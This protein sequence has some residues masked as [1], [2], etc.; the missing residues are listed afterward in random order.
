MHANGYHKSRSSVATASVRTSSEKR[1]GVRG[2]VAVLGLIGTTLTSPS[3][4]Q[5]APVLGTV[6]SFAVLGASTVTNTGS[7]VLTGT[8][9]NPG[10]LGVSPGSAITGF[11]PGSLTG[12]AATIHLN[13]AVAIQAQIDLTKAFNTLTSKPATANLTG[14][15]LGGLTLTPGVY[16]FS[17]AAQLT[18]ALTLNGLGNP[19]SV[20]IFNIGSTLTTASASAISLINGAQGGNVFWRVGSSATL[21]TTTSFAGDILAN[22]SITL[23]TGA[24]ITCGAAWAETGAVTLDTNMIS[25]CDLIGGGGGAILGP[26]GVPLIAS[27][28]PS[29]ANANQRAVANAIDTFT[30]NGGTLPLGFLNLFNLS[31]SNLGNA[32]TQLSGEVGTGAAQAG[33]QAMNSFLSLVTNPFAEN[34]PFAQNRP[35]PP[36]YVKAVPGAAAWNP[37]PQRWGIWGAAYG[38]QTKVAGDALGVGS[39]DRSASAAGFATGLDYR[40][41]PYTVVGFALGGGGTNYGLSNGLGGGHSDMFQAA[42]Y[43]LTQVNA[44]YV[45]AAIAYGFHQFQTDRYVTVAGADHLIADFDANNIGARLE[46]GYRFAIPSLGWPGQSGLT[47]YAALQAQALRTP[48]YSETALSGASDFA[49]SYAA[50]TNTTIRTELGTWLDWS[51]PVDKGTRLSLFGRGAW[52]HD[53][54]SAPN[55]TAGFQALPGSS[56]VVT[57]AAPATDLLLASAG[58]QVG[59]RNGFSLGAQFDGEFAENSRTY[60][61]MG[62]VRYTW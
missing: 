2:A 33:I 13:D 20:F 27:L 58:V 49:L 5:Q 53:D 54:W 31:P 18:G 50:R 17:S 39:H 35:A 40:I 15:N 10:D 42:L 38:G 48:S 14:Q 62:W 22:A 19:N 1:S 55:I 25:L 3:H 7:T 46:G 21:G 45:S 37:D 4:A 51:I 30:A 60:S 41:T 24:K 11:P 28:L 8:A 34:R 56:F 36:M 23:N 16:S 44:A 47:P 12:P 59:F 61:G 57:G 9:A 32:L 6:A 29:S 26:T 43:S 52:A